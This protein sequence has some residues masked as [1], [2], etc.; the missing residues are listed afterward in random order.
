MDLLLTDS[1]DWRPTSSGTPSASSGTVTSQTQNG[2][3]R[4]TTGYHETTLERRE[5]TYIF[6]PGAGDD[7]CHLGYN[8]YTMDVEQDYTLIEEQEQEFDEYRYYQ[9]TFDLTSLY[10]DDRITFDTGTEGAD[11]IHQWN[12]CIEEA[13]TVSNSTFDP[14][15]SGAYDLDID[16][17]PSLDDEKWAPALPD[18]VHYRYDYN[19]YWTTSQYYT[20]RD[21]DNP[22]LTCPKAAMRL[23]EITARSDLE[24]YLAEVPPSGSSETEGMIAWGSTYH[25]IGMIWGGRF[26]SPDGIFAADNATTAGGDAISRHIV[27]MTDGTQSTSRTTYNVYGI[28]W[29]DRRVSGDGSSTTLSNNHAERFQAA[30]RAARNKNISVWVVAFGTT[31]TQNLIDCATPGRA[32][33]AS[34]GTELDE[35]FREIAERI[36]ELRLTD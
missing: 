28:E 20:T 2:D 35:K 31:L 29:W 21:Y 30:C 5:K 23:Q 24:D 33:S 3:I 25:D 6:T 9:R 18:L 17:V 27:F 32:F 11:E 12:G 15:P 16:L 10:D 8:W 34:N 26:I 19:W 7:Q 13:N 36:A 22:R 14:V 1:F 4:T